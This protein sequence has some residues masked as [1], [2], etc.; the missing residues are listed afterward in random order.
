MEPYRTIEVAPVTATIGAVVSGLD[1]RTPMT[2]EEA[3]EVQD[4]L[5]SHCVLFFRD[6]DLTAHQ[7]LDFASRFGSVNL[8]DFAPPDAAGDDKYIDWLEDTSDRPP[9]ADLWHTDRTSWPEPP[10]YA[11][12]NARDV[13][14]AGG[15]TLWLSLY[16]LYEALSP[17]L[18]EM[19]DGL[20]I[21]VRPSRP[22]VN[23]PAPGRRH[24]AYSADS[25][26]AGTIHPLV[27]VHPL[28]KRKAVYLCG[29]SMYGIIG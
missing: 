22:S 19:I 24:I 12:L 21:D 15:D 27:R 2:D 11:I 5:L 8:S 16:A 29:F 3:R 13:P 25:D 20:R 17:V 10:D 4:A 1:L 26:E 9:A 6:Q 23:E 7:Q 14:P 28:T 18:Q